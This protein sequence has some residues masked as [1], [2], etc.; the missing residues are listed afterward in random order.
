MSEQATPANRAR[1]IGATVL[2]VNLPRAVG[3]ERDGP[4]RARDA[5][6]GL[7]DAERVAVHIRGEGVEQNDIALR[8]AVAAHR[9]LYANGRT[10]F[11]G[12]RN[13][14]NGALIFE[15]ELVRTNLFPSKLPVAKAGG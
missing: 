8:E 1:A 15:D 2:N 14:V 7:G 10:G 12:Q 3:D 6:V 5:G 13:G 9:G 4:C 11:N